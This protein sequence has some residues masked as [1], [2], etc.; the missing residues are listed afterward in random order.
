MEIKIGTTEKKVLDITQND[1]SHYHARLIV[2][3]NMRLVL[4]DMGST[5]GT[6]V[7]GH[8]VIRKLVNLDTV[9]RLGSS[10]KFKVSQVVPAHLQDAIAMKEREEIK[11]RF[12]NLENIWNVYSAEK[13]RIQKEGNKSSMMMR[14]PYLITIASGLI[15][16]LCSGSFYLIIGILVGSFVISSVVVRFM[17][18]K[19]EKRKAHINK[20]MEELDAKFKESYLCPNHK[21]RVF[22]GYLPYTSLK[23]TGHCN[24]CHCSYV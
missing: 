21:C 8:K 20:E 19:S 17:D 12:S 2:D 22:L 23:T 3:D 4:E 15:T 7:Q 1:V 10:F 6:Y 5:N 18:R 24:R 9:V 13:S 11:Q 16:R 14:L